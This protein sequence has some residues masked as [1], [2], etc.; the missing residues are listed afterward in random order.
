MKYVC[1]SS[2]RFAKDVVE[3]NC[4]ARQRFVHEGALDVHC[5]RIWTQI[6]ARAHHSRFATIYGF[7]LSATVH[8]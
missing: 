4:D 5:S 2:Q 8:F 3:I 6:L 7:F 1:N